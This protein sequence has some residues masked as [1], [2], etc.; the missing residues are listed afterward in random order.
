MGKHADIRIRGQMLQ[1]DLL[2]ALAIKRYDTGQHFIE[3]DTE[4]VDVDL[5]AV[6]SLAN[7]GGHVVECTYA[8]GLA[9]SAGRADVL[10]QTIVANFYERVVDKDV[11]GLQIAVHDP[12]VVQI[13]DSGGELREEGNGF[14]QIDVS[15]VAVDS[16]AKRFSGDELHNDPALVLFVESNVID[17]DQVRMAKVEA[18][19]HPADFDLQ[20]LLDSLQGDFF[21]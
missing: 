21:A 2:A 12:L 8:L 4:R 7:F 20:V 9:P 3:N 18:V 11:G 6:L 15:G 16:I 19:P 14:V 10:A 5:F 17:P 1:D 13:S